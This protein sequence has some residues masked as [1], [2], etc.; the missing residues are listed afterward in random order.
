MPARRLSRT[1]LH[2]AASAVMLVNS[3]PASSAELSFPADNA[4]SRAILPYTPWIF[5]LIVQSG[6]NFAEI[7]YDRRG[8]DPV[9]GTFFVGGLHVK[10]DVIDFE[11]GR[12]RADLN[13]IMMERIAVDTHG[14]D[15]PPQLREG[16]R[17]IGRDRIEGN[18]LLDIK[19]NAARSAYDIALRYDM[20][21]IGALALNA[22]IDDLH[23][24]VPLS[25]LE[26]AG[27]SQEPTLSGAL[28]KASVA[29]KDDGLMPVAIDISAGEAG[30]SPDQLAAG[31]MTMPSQFA[32]QMIA[33]LPGGV[34][35]ALK[36]RIFAWAGAAETFLRDRGAIRVTF[37]PA[38]PVPLQRFQGGVID[39][40]LIAALN[41]NVTQGF[42]EVVGAPP[43][44]SSLG[45][46]GLLISGTGA[47]QDREAGARA[48]LMLAQSGDLA[49]VRVMAATFGNAP[50]PE[51]QPN[52]LAGLYGYLLVARALDGGIGDPTLSALTAKL[53][54]D[55]VLA[56]EREAA[57]YFTAHGAAGRQAIGAETIGSYDA[58]AIRVAAF[59][60]Y[61]GRGVPRDF[62]RALTLALV[63]SAAGDPFAADL[64]DDLTGAV[65]RKEIVLAADVARTEAAKLWTAYQAA[66]AR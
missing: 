34:S 9:T 61:E 10:R 43:P 13:S 17:K 51:L 41:P 66:Q 21:D 27:F 12:L 19:M 52:E 56:A 33:G 31:I 35:P 14:L 3:A 22:T 49:S 11:V 47:P 48:L 60:Y 5:D 63:A 32:A 6:R 54:P 4:L 38:Q 7:T 24:L 59:D 64:R 26:N 36:D 65:Q 40:A 2:A 23:I 28:V 45:H 58:D 50:A 44:A 55:A 25:D 53:P 57:A 37:S 8:Y 1:I 29:Y 16:L 42:G 20:P 62:T 39:E 46:A 15:L 18:V 30:M